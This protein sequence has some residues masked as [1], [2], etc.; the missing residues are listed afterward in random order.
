[1]NEFLPPLSSQTGILIAAVFVLAGF[2][3]GVVGVGMPTVA[4]GLLTASIGLQ[5]ALALMAVPT[6][7][8][9]IWQG[10]AGPHLRALTKRLWTY[11][12]SATA[13]TCAGVG[14]LIWLDHP[15][16]PLILAASLILYG[17]AALM[18][19][20]MS[21][22]A[23]QEIWMSPSL[24][25]LNGILMG[26]TGSGTVPGVFYFDSL[27]LSRDEMVQA[28]GLLFLA[29]TTALAATLAVLSTDTGAIDRRYLLLSA[30]C[31]VP[32][33]VGIGI[34]TRVRHRLSETRFRQVLYMAFIAMGIVIAARTL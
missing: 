1:M 9:N 2:V 25:A 33:I 11:M 8:T 31:V 26:L 12:A 7:I 34:G 19:F 6:I 30:L 22:R 15:L 3:K 27:K 24:G 5:P 13:F 18:K 17:T 14:L 16:L 4:V 20:R 10:F 23:D 21:A 32:A 28:M 29:I